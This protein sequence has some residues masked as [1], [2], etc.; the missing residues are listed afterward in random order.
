[1]KEQSI[2]DLAAQNIPKKRKI[3]AMIRKDAASLEKDFSTM[4]KEFRLK[5]EDSHT[6]FVDSSMINSHTP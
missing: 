1:M 2:Y 3:R 5:T 4:D 6:M